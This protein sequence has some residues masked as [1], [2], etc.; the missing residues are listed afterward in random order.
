[1]KAYFIP[2]MMGE[3][4]YHLKTAMP[5]KSWQEVRKMFLGFGWTVEQIE[6]DMDGRGYIEHRVADGKIR[7]VQED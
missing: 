2:A 1:M 7:Y 5:D 4:R 3:Y 6:Q